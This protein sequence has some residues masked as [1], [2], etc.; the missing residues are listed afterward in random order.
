MAKLDFKKLA[1]KAVKDAVKSAGK[2]APA[3]KQTV[4]WN[5]TF[6]QSDSFKGYKRIKL[7]TYKEF[8][9][10]ATLAH[11]AKKDYNFKNSTIQLQNVRVT[12]ANDFKAVNVY[13]DA[14]RIGC[15]YD[16]YSSYED[17]MKDIDAVHLKVD[18]DVYLFVHYAE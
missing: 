1:K 5:K 12:G 7:T 18:G 9:V 2:P 11:F 14:M 6:R 8:G 16:T 3:P 4:L 17:L 15:T 10:D 13:A